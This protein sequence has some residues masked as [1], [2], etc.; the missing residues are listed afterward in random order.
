MNAKRQELLRRG[1][2]GSMAYYMA[3]DD[4][5]WLFR[6]GSSEPEPEPKWRRYQ[7]K[8][9]DKQFDDFCNAVDNEGMHPIDAAK[10]FIK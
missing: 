5:P 8:E 3:P 9:F 10:K 4:D 7:C 2:S 6:F 1:I